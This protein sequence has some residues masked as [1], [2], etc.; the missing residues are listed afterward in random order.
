MS[1]KDLDDLF[2]GI[3]FLTTPAVADYVERSEA[4]VRVY[5]S[6]LGVPRAG[7]AFVWSRDHVET[8]IDALGFEDE[9]DQD[10]EESEETDDDE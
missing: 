2:D 1:K 6:E 9:G 10:D 8:L 5:G 7:Q 3:E 4:T